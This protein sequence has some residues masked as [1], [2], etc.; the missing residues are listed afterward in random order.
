MNA[1]A[2]YMVLPSMTK[3]RQKSP[4]PV[5]ISIRIP[6]ETLRK[7]KAAA[8]AGHRTVSAEIIKRIEEFPE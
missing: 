2:K 6:T 3:E 8:K 7:L 4:S 5:A 1:S